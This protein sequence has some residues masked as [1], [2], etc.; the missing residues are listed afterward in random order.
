M[1]VVYHFAVQKNKVLFLKKDR[2]GKMISAGIIGATGYAGVELVRI[3]LRHSG[4]AKLYLSSV[5]FEGQNITDIYPNLAGQLCNK[6][7]GVLLTADDVKQK[8]DIVFT[9]L[10]NGLAEEYAD[11]CVKNGKK[12]IDLSAD[13]RFN[14]D[15]ATFKKWYKADWKFPAVHKESVYGLPEMNR[16][17]IAKA[18]VIG[19]PGCFVTSATLGL[20][21]ALKENIIKTDTIIVDSKSGVTGA[22]RNPTMT[23]QFCECG[24]SFSPYKVGAHRHQP[25]IA[26]NCTVAAGKPVGIVFTPHLLPMSRGIISTM[27]APLTDDF[28][29]K[30]AGKN[31]ED[32]SAEVRVLYKDFYKNEPFVR[33]LAAGVNPTTR[34]VRY[35]NFCDVQVYV[36]NEGT[37]LEVVSA[38]DNMVKGAA[39]QA[40]QNMNLMYGFDETE[41]INFIPPAF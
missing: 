21:P 30:I 26:K 4:V 1:A 35:S 8:S 19:N 9:A 34:V 10:P 25:E 14:L 38:L 23:N 33:V 40:V 5:S 22:G 13:F 37:M 17:R 2:G 20:L 32:A 28:A 27:Y 41:G 39:G 11:Y 36:V 15:E 29:K 18:R 3:L 24:E 12:L 7:D 16:E 6:T 31:M